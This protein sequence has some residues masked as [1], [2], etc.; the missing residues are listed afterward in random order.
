ME[1]QIKL[2][3]LSW[4]EPFAKVVT[5]WLLQ[6][7]PAMDYTEWVVVTPGGRAGRRITSLLVSQAEQ[8]K[9]AMVPPDMCTVGSLPERL[10]VT[11]GRSAGDLARA[12]AWAQA[13]REL[14]EGIRGVLFP[15]PPRHN[16]I[17]G[18]LRLAGTIERC[19]C[20]LAAFGLSFAKVAALAQQDGRLGRADRWEAA[21]A[22]ERAY[23]AQLAAGGWVDPQQARLEALQRGALRPVARVVVAGVVQVSGQLRMLLKAAAETG[24]GVDVLVYGDGLERFDELGCVKSAAWA[25]APLPLE[26][27]TV[28][29]AEGPADTAREV[30]GALARI[31][32][33]TTPAVDGVTI[34][35]LSESLVPFIEAEALQLGGV[36][37]RFGAGR[38]ITES[39]PYR[40]LTMA[41]EFLRSRRFRHFVALVRH[42]DIT[43]SLER[44]WSA[45]HTEAMPDWLRVLDRY[46]T[47]YLPDMLDVSCS[48]PK[49]WRSTV[50]LQDDADAANLAWLFDRICTLV[51]APDPPE[52]ARVPADWA[53][54]ILRTLQRA[55]GEPP[56]AGGWNMHEPGERAVITACGALRECLDEQR[57]LRHGELTLP[58]AIDVLL[59]LV[60]A[61]RLVP[62]YTG[63]QVDMVGWLELM[64]DDAEYLIVTGLNEGLVPEAAGPD[65]FLNDSVRKLLGLDDDA[66]RYAR[67]AYLLS[68][69]LASRPKGSVTLITARR[70]P[71]GDPLLP[72]RLLLA[73]EA[74]AVA[75]QLQAYVAPRR[76]RPPLAYAMR[77][78]EVSGFGKVCIPPAERIEIPTSLRVTA[79]REYLASP[80][81]FY[82]RLIR[83]LETMPEDAPREI[84]G[85]DFGSFVHEILREAFGVGDPQRFDSRQA[86]EDRLLSVLHAKVHTVY[87]DRLAASL[88]FQVALLEKRLGRLA[89]WQDRWYRQGWRMRHWEWKG[90]QGANI[91]VDGTPMGLTGRIDRVDFHEPT[92]SWAVLDYKVC[93]GDKKP[94]KT[95]REGGEWVDLQLPLYRYLAA[96]L[97]RLQLGY[98]R[99][100]D[101][102]ACI[103]EALATWD[104]AALA[105]ADEVA[106]DVVRKIRQGQFTDPGDRPP[107][108]G[109]FAY[110][111]GAGLIDTDETDAEEA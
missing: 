36:P 60:R 88:R 50:A 4:D 7:Q 44:E 25:K 2:S 81:G 1:R 38:P 34:G 26:R 23:R 111:F 109:S 33:E 42:P 106:R 99:V 56:H 85:V 55:Y 39:R 102:P 14:P 65:P 58:D 19:Q 77:A 91:E 64:P 15:Q 30:F 48:E 10:L 75:R 11:E 9:L 59:S 87:G 100:S 22:L 68:A 27:A 62:D 105:E 21:A 61:A 69:M 101:D 107:M 16:D 73:R 66:A 18:W 93:T 53:E 49:G 110:I 74:S 67:D 72:S 28:T 43:R 35:V 17:A 71:E 84:L 80:Q 79:F 108:D 29:V 98:V 51:S 32:Q 92:G 86:W 78:S 40:L 24:I 46:A 70:S 82:L 52:L 103:G 54:K 31:C 89:D 95:H 96:G 57:G 47:R 76:P 3:A 20:E 13:L 63:E 83:G 41:A 97:G 94:E 90:N 12:L 5:Q 6:A 104:D 37:V 8:R 45:S